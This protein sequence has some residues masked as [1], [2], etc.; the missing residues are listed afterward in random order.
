MKTDL[1]IRIT[2][3][4]AH[5]PVYSL[6]NIYQDDIS[7]LQTELNLKLVHRFKEN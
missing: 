6:C 1:I 3:C 7:L 4:Q 2:V 5:R